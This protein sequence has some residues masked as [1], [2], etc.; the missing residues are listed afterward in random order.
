MEYISKPLFTLTAE[1]VEEILPVIEI[2]SARL[3]QQII[4]NPEI[5]KSPYEEYGW[6][7]VKQ[8]IL[9]K[10]VKRIKKFQDE[11]KL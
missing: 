2:E 1:E 4:E 3:C 8:E 11:N 7:T 10:I 9:G 5:L 6:I